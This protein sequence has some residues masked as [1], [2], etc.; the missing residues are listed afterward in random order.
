MLFKKGVTK[1]DTPYHWR[2]L[3]VAKRDVP[4]LGD[5]GRTPSGDGG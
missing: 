2:A 3:G 4:H 1:R 5:G